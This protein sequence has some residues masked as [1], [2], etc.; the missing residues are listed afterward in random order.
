MKEESIEKRKEEARREMR[1]LQ[2]VVDLACATIRSGTVDY[3]EAMK[4]FY[5]CRKWAAKLS[6]ERL[7][8]FDMIYGS[9][10]KRLIEEYIV[11]R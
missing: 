3:D 1:L 9:R 10:I 4:L 5:G 6:P 7:D 11:E 8:L 2:T